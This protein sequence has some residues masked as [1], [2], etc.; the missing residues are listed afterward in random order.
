MDLPDRL[1]G[2]R[3]LDS[4]SEPTDSTGF[5]PHYTKVYTHKLPCGKKVKVKSGTQIIDRFWGILRQGLKYISRKPGTCLLER[6]V[7]SIQWVYCHKGT[8]IWKATGEMLQFVQ[9]A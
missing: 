5:K 6:K 3:T 7:R 2:E 9:K 4:T 8:N 1:P